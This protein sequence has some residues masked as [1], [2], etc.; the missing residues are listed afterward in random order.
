[1]NEEMSIFLV[2]Q[3]KRT[4]TGVGGTKPL[5]RP[6]GFLSTKPP[7]TWVRWSFKYQARSRNFSKPRDLR[8]ELIHRSKI[9]MHLDSSAADTPVK[10]WSDTVIQTTDLVSSRLY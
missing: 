9:Y 7:V 1:M 10:I 6:A 3:Y 8:L 4:L 2:G 5:S